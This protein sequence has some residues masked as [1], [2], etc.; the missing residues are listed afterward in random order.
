M[1]TRTHFKL[2]YCKSL[3]CSLP[4]NLKC[5]VCKRYR[6]IML[7]LVVKAPKS[8]HILTLAY[9]NERIAIQTYEVLTY[10]RVTPFRIIRPNH[11]ATA[12]SASYCI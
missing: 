10:F 12:A 5:V 3:Y 8:S 1:H 2:D 6:I 11:C 7:S 4:K 9:T